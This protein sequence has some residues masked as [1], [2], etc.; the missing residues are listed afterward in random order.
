MIR[1]LRMGAPNQELLASSDFLKNSKTFWRTQLKFTGR[2]VL[3]GSKDHVEMHHIHHIR[4][5]KEKEGFGRIMSLLNRKQIPV[6]KFHH[7]AIHDGR[8]DNI[9]LSE[10]YDTRIAQVENSLNLDSPIE[11][12]YSKLNC[13]S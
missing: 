12:P 4:N 8:Y 1:N 6:C 11:V 9:S 13:F 7:K 10:L 2:C 5:S 3:C